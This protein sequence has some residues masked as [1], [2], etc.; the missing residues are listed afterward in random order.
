MLNVKQEIKYYFFS[1]LY[2]S[3]WD[4]TPVTQAI[5]EHPTN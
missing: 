3:T 1:L 4:W 5:G 2:Y